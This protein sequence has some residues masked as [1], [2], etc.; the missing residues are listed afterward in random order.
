[1]TTSPDTTPD[2]A[3]VDQ[4]LAERAATSAAVL[5]GLITAGT[6]HAAGQPDQLP[7]LLFP[8]VPPEH[9]QAIWDAALAVGM[10]AGQHTARSRWDTTDLDQARQQLYDAGYTAM[11]RHTTAAAYAAP[12]RPLPH[13]ADHEPPLEHP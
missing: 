3:T 13:P 8:N 1:M 11:A 6:L 5:A 2:T 10:W 4:V 12:S 7:A 9:V